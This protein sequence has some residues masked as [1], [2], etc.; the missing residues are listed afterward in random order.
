M[1]M[2]VLL[3]VDDEPSILDMLEVTLRKEGFQEILTARTGEEAV[4]L[5]RKGRPDLVLLDVMLPDLE[6]FEVCRQLRS[7]T[8]VP[9]LFLTARSNDLDKLMGLGIGGDDYITKPFNPLEVAAR[10]KAQL[11]RQQLVGQQIHEEKRVHDWG[12]FCVDEEA[13]QLTVEGTVIPCPARE[14]QLLVFLCRHPNRIFSKS[15]LYEQVWGEESLGDDNTV[16]VHVRRLREKIEPNPATPRY[17]VT[18]RGL[19][20]KLLPPDRRNHRDT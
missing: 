2:A 4:R 19:G 13:G 14:F 18:V 12:R 8:T 11:R 3:L 15:Q 16:M 5:A 9:I 10:V 17:L 20:Y 6:G 7:F 1:K